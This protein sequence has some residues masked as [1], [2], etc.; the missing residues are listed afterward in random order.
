MGSDNEGD[1]WFVDKP[2]PLHLSDLPMA[3]M[4][5]VEPDYLKV[6]QVR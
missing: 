2:K 3:I 1:F 4:Y 5:V 6:M